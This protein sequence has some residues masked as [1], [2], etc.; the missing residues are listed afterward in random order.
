MSAPRAQTLARKI[1]AG[2]FVVTAELTPPK[3]TDLT[4]L[5]AKADALMDVVDAVNL[6][7]SPRARM[8]VEPKSVG[9]LLL[10]RGLEPIVQMTARDRNRIAIQADL[11]GGVVLGLSNYLFM[12]GDSP[13]NGDHPDA[14]GVFDWNAVDMLS[15][16][17]CLNRGVDA[18]GAELKGS[19][20][21]FV[22]A[23]VNPTAENFAVEVENT[24]RKIDAGARFLQTQALF[25]PVQLEKFLDA[26]KPNVAVLGGI[27]PLKSLKMATWL[28][29]NVPG[30]KVPDAL[31]TEVGAAKSPE[32]ELR[33]G[34]EI[35]T[36][37]IGQIKRLCAGVHIMAMGWES[38]IPAMLREHKVR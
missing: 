7:D 30:I 35:A 16:A 8:T 3:G 32:D 20:K 13:K 22:G 21:L 4:E 18:G 15:A 37:L 29:A 9:H 28:N 24:R 34:V 14:K 10:Q 19:V 5:F 2:Q 33:S 1:D 12:G 26:V 11:L 17:R 25:E 38:H 6:T 23:T 31:L 27:I 36:R